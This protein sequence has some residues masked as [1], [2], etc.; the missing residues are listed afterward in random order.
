LH[1]DLRAHK[2]LLNESSVCRYCFDESERAIKFADLQKEDEGVYEWIRVEGRTEHTCKLYIKVYEEITSISINQTTHHHNDTCVVT[3]TCTTPTKDVTFSWNRTNEDLPHNSSILEIHL[4]SDDAQSSYTCTVK[5]PVSELSTTVTPFMR[6]ASPPEQSQTMLYVALSVVS[7]AVLVPIILFFVLR[8]E[9][10]CRHKKT[11]TFTVTSPERA[12]V[13]EPQTPKVETIY[14]TVDK[15]PP[16]NLSSAADTS[17]TIYEL[18]GH[19]L[20]KV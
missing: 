4:T 18:A 17:M 11:G 10:L 12:P 5:N 19:S 9:V 6:C 2:D 8:K 1:Y 16:E 14:A 13:P 20:A 3:L 7:V 15:K